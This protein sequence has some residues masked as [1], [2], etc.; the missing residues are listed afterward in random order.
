[1]EEHYVVILVLDNFINMREVDQTGT[2][3]ESMPNFRLA[4]SLESGKT[5][6]IEMLSLE[7]SRFTLKDQRFNPLSLLPA[8]EPSFLNFAES[9]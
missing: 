8:D 1:M 4:R 7:E 2:H 3:I 9:S 5:A 6:T